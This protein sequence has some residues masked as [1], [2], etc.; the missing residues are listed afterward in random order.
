ML[1]DAL[2]EGLQTD[3][4]AYRGRHEEVERLLENPAQQAAYLRLMARGLQ[5]VGELAAAFDYCQ[6]LMDLDTERTPLDQISKVLTTRRDRW[7][8]SELAAL[9]REAKEETAARIDAGV[10]ARLKAAM[11]AG[12]IE[13]LQQFLDYF[14]D[15]PCASAA[16]DQLVSRLKS[17]GR[18]LEAE[19]IGLE[20]PDAAG[21]AEADRLASGRRETAWP[22][23][24][25]EV[26]SPSKK[27][28]P[29][30]GDAQSPIEW[31]GNPGR[32]FADTTLNF[33]ARG[34]AILSRDAWGREQWRVSLPQENPG[35]VNSPWDHAR[36]RG[37]LL[38]VS[39]GW[40]IAAI[41]T[42]GSGPNGTPRLLWSQNLVVP[43][44]DSPDVR[45]FR[46]RMININMPAQVQFQAQFPME[47]MQ[48]FGRSGPLGPV[49]SRYVCFQRLRSLMAM[50]PQSGAVLWS[51]QDMPVASEVFG[52]DEYVFVVSANREE[53]TLL[54]AADGEVLGT[55][56]IPRPTE[57]QVRPGGEEKTVF[58]RLEDSYLATLGRRL[59]QWRQKGDECELAL[60]D[61]LDGKDLWPRRKFSANAR[62][63]VVGEEVVGVMEPWVTEPAAKDPSGR[64]V[65]VSLPDGRTIGEVA[66]KPERSLTEI[67]LLQSG[68]QYFLVT[69]GS[70]LGNREP[71][72]VRNASS[73]LVGQG[74]VYAMDL[75]GRLQWPAPVTVK[76]QVML[77][78]PP[79]N[80]PIL[81]FA[82]FN[83]EQNRNGQNLPKF[84]VLCLD[85]RNGRTVYAHEFSRPSPALIITGDAQQKT[86]DLTMQRDTV[87]LT[88]T[89]KPLPSSSAVGSRP[90][91][92]PAGG[93]TANAIWDSLQKTFGR[94][95]D[96]SSQEK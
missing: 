39:L 38:L 25:V 86:V 15:Q 51:R 77:L 11:A 16:R 9:R 2:L 31:R 92:P 6:K 8:R 1:R 29:N 81:A 63:C 89:D 26:A 76:S 19:L 40:R 47:L 4:A 50:D 27:P 23:G 71:Q 48:S 32:F 54:R 60:F 36:A 10:E 61:P 22:V 72:P 14:G 85:K 91:E 18:L 53:A 24:E 41:D 73:K 79:A 58:S 56:K 17:A 94:I 69:H 65:L 35:Y 88:F 57:N 74:K 7:V 67:T 43:D 13:R 68:D 33:N 52:D 90:G 96:E 62:A 78:H 66:L 42:L 3:F 83:Y 87:T 12:S 82:S 93:K 80:V 95:L 59:L 30:S 84:S 20:G 21:P 55:R 46:A 34:N 5:Q 49:T 64:F 37:H 45:A 44:N 70:P 75:Q 28:T